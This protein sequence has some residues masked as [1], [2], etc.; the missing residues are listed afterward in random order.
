[1][2]MCLWNDIFLILI[3]LSSYDY[4]FPKKRKYKL[5]LVPKVPSRKFIILENTEK[6]QFS[7]LYFRLSE[8]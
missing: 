4:L 7:T 1:M 5:F 2:L 6:N 3:I 8:A